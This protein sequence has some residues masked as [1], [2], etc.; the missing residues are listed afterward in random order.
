[1]VQSGAKGEQIRN[2]RKGAGRRFGRLALLLTALTL[3]IPCGAQARK[4]FHK[5]A[6]NHWVVVDEAAAK[7]RR[8]TLSE[9]LTI[10]EITINVEYMDPEGTGFMDADFGL[11]RRECVTAALTAIA[12]TL[13]YPGGTLDVTMKESVN[14]S[15]ANYIA[16]GWTSFPAGLNGYFNGAAYEHLTNGTDID[17]TVGDLVCEVNF[18]PP[19]YSGAG[20]PPS[21]Q[22]DM[23]SILLHEFTHG[24]GFLSLAYIDY[25]EQVKSSA[26]SSNP[27]VFSRWDSMLVTGTGT[28][29][30]ASGGRFA[31]SAATLEGSSPGV[32]FNGLESKTVNGGNRPQVFTPSLFDPDSSL[33]HWKLG[34]AK[35]IMA[36][37]A[38]KGAVKR[39][40]GELDEAALKDLGWKLHAVPV[41]AAVGP[42]WTFYE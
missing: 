9:T 8:A 29:L 5:D 37:Y 36:P 15:E 41:R 6:P 2:G 4:F 13:S 27:G 7:P 24:L 25:T 18:F 16:Y 19:L 12:T 39:E 10:N 40:Y 34:M 38:T 33:S 42:N 30:F 1:M 11:S 31:G 35:T 3:L 20:T 26:S 28:A 21:D 17:P 22:Y 14:D 23:T 32:F